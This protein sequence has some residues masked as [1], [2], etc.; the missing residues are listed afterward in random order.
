MATKKVLARNW[1]F[2]VENPSTAGVYV[3]INGLTEFGMS[4]TKNDVD[5][6]DFNSGG[7][8]EHQVASRGLSLDLTGYF[9]EDDTGKRDEGQKIVDD[10]GLSVGEDSIGKFR[11]TSPNGTVY[12]FDGTV[13]STSPSGGG[14]DDNTGWEVSVRINGKPVVA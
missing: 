1:L 4:P 2:E 13:E 6:T 5:G 8:E 12:T 10:Y 14:T 11:M 7:W 3:K 9:L